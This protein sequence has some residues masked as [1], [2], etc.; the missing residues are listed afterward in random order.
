MVTRGVGG[1]S[2]F[3]AAKGTGSGWACDPVPDTGSLGACWA[4]S[5]VCPPGSHRLGRK[6]GLCGRD[7][8]RGVPGWPGPSFQPHKALSQDV[9]PRR[10]Q[11]AARA[12]ITPGRRRDE[13]VRVP[14][15]DQ[16][17]GS[18]VPS[19]PCGLPG[20][21]PFRHRH[22]HLGCGPPQAGLRAGCRPGPQLVLPTR[23]PPASGGGGQWLWDPRPVLCWGVSL[24][25]GLC[26][27][28]FVSVG[29][30]CSSL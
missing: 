23:V 20:A 26:L 30:G 6:G 4:S 24:Y 25:G 28:V 10:S 11:D 5:L 22:S 19:R 29:G 15:G 8:G 27:W 7:K 21:A 2:G 13:L 18:P 12:S 16:R 14:A 9:G 3:A 17:P 1:G